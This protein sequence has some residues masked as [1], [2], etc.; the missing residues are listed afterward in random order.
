MKITSLKEYGT[1]IRNL[2]GYDNK[3]FDRAA[4][5]SFFKG[6]MATYWSDHMDHLKY[7]YA[8]SSDCD[9]CLTL[10]WCEALPPQRIDYQSAFDR[11]R[12]AVRAW[13]NYHNIPDDYLVVSCWGNGEDHSV[14]MEMF[15]DLIRALLD[16]ADFFDESSVGKSKRGVML[17]FPMFAGGW[18]PREEDELDALMPYADNLNV[19]EEVSYDDE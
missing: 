7:V 15:V 6:A 18:G 16:Y 9:G 14:F 10:K 19:E 12:T 1:I 17:S 11:Y 2:V 8:F 5:D 13:R 3:T 4:I